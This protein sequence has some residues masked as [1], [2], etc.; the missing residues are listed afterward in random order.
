[1]IVVVIIGLLSAIAIPNYIKYQ[2][3]AKIGRTAAEMRNLSRGFF[4]YY[5]GTGR[6]PDDSHGALPAG[7]D[8]YINPAIW[9]EETPIGGNYNWEGP[10]TYPY[11][12]IAI[13]PND[14][15]PVEEL[16]ALDHLLDDGDLAAGR[17]RIGINGKPTL[18][19]EE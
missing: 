11:V 19:I 1:M 12:G 6:Y 15:V 18:I 7:M 10:D 14:A 3:T 8:E 2:R 4:A 13:F 16:T 9:A 17:F 5:A